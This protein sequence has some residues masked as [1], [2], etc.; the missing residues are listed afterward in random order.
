MSFYRIAP[1]LFYGTRDAIHVMHVM[2]NTVALPCMW[3]RA[4][5]YTAQCSTQFG[6][7]GHDVLSAGVAMRAHWSEDIK[8][9]SIQEDAPHYRCGLPCV[10]LHHIGMSV[11]TEKLPKK[12]DL[13]PCA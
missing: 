10:H 5:H 11:Q 13:V 4:V 2:A 3:H 6:L 7:D 8:Q 12:Q 9:S 1:K